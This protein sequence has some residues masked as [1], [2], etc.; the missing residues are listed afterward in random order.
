MNH[1][2]RIFFHYENGRFAGVKG[3]P[4]ANHV[5]NCH[6]LLAAFDDRYFDPTTKDRLMRAVALHDAGKTDTFRILAETQEK[7][8]G[9]GKQKGGG[10]GTANGKLIYSFAGHRFR[11]PGDDPYVDALIRA[12]HEFSVERINQ[13]RFALSGDARRRFA[14]DLYL[15][16]MADQIEAE[17]AVK[18]V[19]NKT[20]GLPRTFMEFVTERLEDSDKAF[21]VLPWPFQADEVSLVFDL[22]KPEPNPTEPDAEFLDRLFKNPDTEFQTERLS[23]TLRRTEWS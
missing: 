9:K 21:T 2:G 17:L 14:D 7:P 20:G 18:T 12:H 16:C 1:W 8:A 6:D 23:I 5:G 22:R 10:A 11:V 19:E 4:L 15:L 3:Q 13:E